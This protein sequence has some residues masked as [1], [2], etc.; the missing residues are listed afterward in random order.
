MHAQIKEFLSGGCR[1]NGQK[2]ALTMLFF[3]PQLI[4]Q[5]REGDRSNGFITEKKLEMCPRDT[6]APAI[7]K[8]A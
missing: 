4:L 3:S 7:A 6:D 5:F 2:T 1:P 8:F